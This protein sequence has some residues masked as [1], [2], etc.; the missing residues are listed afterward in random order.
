MNV[1]YV[2]TIERRAEARGIALG[3]AKGEARGIALGEAKGE[4]KALRAT[5]ETLLRARFDD[6]PPWTL[7][8][9]REATVAELNAS[10]Q[11]FVCAKSLEDVFA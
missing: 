4:E 5:L 3:E 2:S 11:N 10:I 1:D 8:R 7:T 6:L 9:I